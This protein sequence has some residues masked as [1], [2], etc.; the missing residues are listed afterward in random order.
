MGKTN[1]KRPVEQYEEPESVVAP[2]APVSTEPVVQE[3]PTTPAATPPAIRQPYTDT[4][5]CPLC[6][7]RKYP[8]QLMGSKC[9]RRYSDDAR[10]SLGKGKFLSLNSW[11]KEVAPLALAAAERMFKETSESYAKTRD[12]ISAKA[13]ELVKKAS[14]GH[15]IDRHIFQGA[16]QDKQQELW[17]E[18]GGNRAFAQMRVAERAVHMLRGIVNGTV[19]PTPIPRPKEEAKPG[20]IPAE[21]P[22]VKSAGN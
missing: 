9:Y 17:K 15:Y 5:V 6:G 2:T 21:T 10:V 7:E 1:R 4:S 19:D 22:M 8:Y 13:L 3:A 20:Q 11:F 12:E 14:G 16:R 18:M